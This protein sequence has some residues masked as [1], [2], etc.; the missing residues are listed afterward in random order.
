MLDPVDI[1]I[2]LRG[3]HQLEAAKIYYT[4]TSG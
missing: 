1:I 2:Y 4:S 3:G